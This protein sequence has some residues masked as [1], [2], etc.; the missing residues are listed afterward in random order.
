MLD[1][2]LHTP[3]TQVLNSREKDETYTNEVRGGIQDIPD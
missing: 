3:S 2:Y 1:K